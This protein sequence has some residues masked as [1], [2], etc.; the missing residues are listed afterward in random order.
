MSDPVNSPEH[1]TQGGEECI[2]HIKR[3]LGTSGFKAFC[4]GNSLKY[5]WRADFKGNKEEDIAKAIW[6]ERIRADDDPRL[7][8]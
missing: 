3:Q 4:L 6:Y 2:D 1:Y 7:D 5:R 8:K